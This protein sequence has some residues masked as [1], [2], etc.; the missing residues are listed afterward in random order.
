MTA[1][2]PNHLST[3]ALDVY[4][5]SG[6]AP[7]SAIEAHLE[8]CARCRGYVA[9]LDGLAAMA[10]LTSER[11]GEKKGA[12]LRPN[13]SRNGWWAWAAAASFA[14]AAGIGVGVS[15]R[16][17]APAGSGYVGIKGTPAVQL[18][19]HRASDTHVW[20]GR[21]PVQPGD[22]LALRVACDGFTKLAIAAPGSNTW[23]RLSQ[24]T[25]PSRDGA[26]P[27]T[28]IVDG[29]PGAERFAVVLSQAPLDDAG[30]ARAIADKQQT[31][32]TWVVEFVLPKEI[33][34]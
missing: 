20:D 23:K 31:S 16:E 32:T 5:A 19:V 14:L 30:L 13:R 6:R 27:F 10:P 2:E 34:R 15:S 21:A 9:S 12:R 28:L 11:A 26:L 7:D 24:V 29:Q 33:K 25:C 3:F 8:A 18:L 4:W 22:A 1:S 17:Q